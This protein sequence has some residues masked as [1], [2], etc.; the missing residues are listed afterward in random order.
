MRSD[1]KSFVVECDGDC[2]DPFGDWC[3]VVVR[4]CDGAAFRD[5]FGIDAVVACGC[6]KDGFEGV[7]GSAHLFGEVGTDVD[8]CADEGVGWCFV[9]LVLGEDPFHGFCDGEWRDV[10]FRVGAAVDYY[11][12]FGGHGIRRGGGRLQDVGYSVTD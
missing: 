2:H 7:G 6:D 9:V 8:V 4:V 3:F 1:L 12:E 5:G 11:A 10:R